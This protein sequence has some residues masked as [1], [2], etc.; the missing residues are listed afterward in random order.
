MRI[1]RFTLIELL[2]VVA[3]I[4]ILASL[5][6]PALSKARD[7]ARQSACTNN[8]KQI[9]TAMSVYADE[10]GDDYPNVAVN[11][12]NA[13]LGVFGDAWSHAD[14]LDLADILAGSTDP[15]VRTAFI[16][17]DFNMGTY[18]SNYSV[19]ASTY[20]VHLHIAGY[21]SS[22]A[23]HPTF[24]GVK[25]DHISDPSQIVIVGDGKYQENPYHVY[26]SFNNSIYLG[27]YRDLGP[28][29]YYRWA[30]DSVPVGAFADGH[31]E[32]RRGPWQSG[33]YGYE[34]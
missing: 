4:A 22:N 23:T 20:S 18:T 17:P 11:S 12:D 29:V 15:A 10:N 24:S 19:V 26:S 7:S 33:Y 9:I 27:G 13:A 5:L 3:I 1:K 16:C 31:V 6:L 34:H 8:L 21:Y 25:R 14:L 32:K 30:H 2:V 28:D